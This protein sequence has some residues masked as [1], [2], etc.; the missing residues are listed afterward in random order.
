MHRGYEPVDIKHPDIEDILCAVIFNAKG[1]LFETLKARGY[2]KA[3][4][5]LEDQPADPAIPQ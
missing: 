3:T 1:Y 5:S 2:G 4:S